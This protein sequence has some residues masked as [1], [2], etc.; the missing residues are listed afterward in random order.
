MTKRASS[1]E[2]VLGGKKAGI[3][4]HR[5]FY[6]GLRKGIL[7]GRLRPEARLA[8]TRDLARQHGLSRGTIV[9]AIEQL[10]SEGYV[11]GRMGSG[12]YV[13]KILPEELLEAKPES[14][15]IS[16]KSE[17]RKLNFSEY[18]KR[19]E[20]FPNLENRPNRAFRC[21]LPALELFPATL[22]AQVAGR[23]LRR[24]SRQDLLGC[25]VMGYRPLREALADYL[26]SSRGVKCEA[27]QVAIVSGVQESIDLVARIFLNAG[28][29]VCMEDPGYP[30]AGAVFEAVGAK[31][32]LAGLDEEGMK[33]QEA[34]LE[35]A[36]LS[37]SRQDTSFRWES[38]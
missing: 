22:W 34:K 12:T 30:G 36:K 16:S 38:Q 8:S 14:G 32:C 21:N 10:K 2:L 19:V 28:D 27:G 3:S 15:P 11:R 6:E 33:P 7:D 29:W 13:S 25:E 4:A 35:K 31:I 23:R 5:W 37:T 17:K 24:L 18:G 20:L 1:F 9:N 26:N